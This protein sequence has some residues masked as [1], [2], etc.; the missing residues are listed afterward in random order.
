M[1]RHIESA[2]HRRPQNVPRRVPGRPAPSK[3]DP[4]YD[5]NRAILADGACALDPDGA[6]AELPPSA[7]LPRHDEFLT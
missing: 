5:L 4:V 2:A 7:R 6:S 1:P 3:G